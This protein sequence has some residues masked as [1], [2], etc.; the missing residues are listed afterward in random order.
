MIAR[1]AHLLIALMCSSFHAFA[2]IPDQEDWYHADTSIEGKSNLQ[3]LRR[4][5]VTWKAYYSSA[6]NDAMTARCF[7]YLQQI[8]DLVTED[9][10]YFK[11]SLYI[12]SILRSSGPSVLMK[13]IMHMLKAKRISAFTHHAG[14]VL[15]RSRFNS[16]DPNVKYGAMSTRELDSLVLS[17]FQ[18]A[19]NLS[20]SISPT[21]A[22]E[23]LWL[24]SDTTIFPFAA[25]MQDLIY[26]ERIAS[27]ARNLYGS[28]RHQLLLFHRK[29]CYRLSQYRY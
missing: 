13:T 20:K 5:L 23:L 29:S 11:N 26:A 14:F 28:R 17:Q 27:F 8:D 15:K 6:K 7:Y 21:D 4:Q 16:Y 10:L 18:I 19:L 22:K 3:D 24:S 2:Q 12:D 25:D 9:T 1:P